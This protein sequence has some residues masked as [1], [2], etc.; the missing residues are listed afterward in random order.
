MGK[1][2][3]SSSAY[4][5]GVLNFEEEVS[6]F[7]LCSIFHARSWRA[8]TLVT[9]EACQRR[10]SVADVVSR[11]QQQQQYLAGILM[12]MDDDARGLGGIGGCTVE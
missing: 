10:S 6:G 7:P 1:K 9:A 5:L 4:W 12:L 8:R 11:Q 2:D 3:Q